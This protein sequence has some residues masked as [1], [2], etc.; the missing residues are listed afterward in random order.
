MVL[1]PSVWIGVLDSATEA[2]SMALWEFSAA[3]MT[4]QLR[5]EN[6]I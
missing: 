2:Y 6:D 3:G 1:E 4:Q 5:F